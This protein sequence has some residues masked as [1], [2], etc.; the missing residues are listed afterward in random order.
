MMRGSVQNFYYKYF[1]VKITFFYVMKKLLIWW[2]N[3]HFCKVM[4]DKWVKNIET[5]IINSPYYNT[6][7]PSNKIHRHRTEFIDSDWYFKPGDLCSHYLYWLFGNH[8][9]KCK[10]LERQI[11]KMFVNGHKDYVT[12]YKIQDLHGNIKEYVPQDYLDIIY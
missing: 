4:H 1:I 5:K 6:Y 9:N 3:T 11:S 7:Y 2:E 8:K 10:I 12:C